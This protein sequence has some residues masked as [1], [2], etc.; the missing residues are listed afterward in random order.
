MNVAVVALQAPKASAHMEFHINIYRGFDRCGFMD[1]GDLRAFWNGS[2]LWSVGVYIGGET[3]QGVGCFI[4]DAAWVAD[5]LS[6]GWGVAFLWDGLQAPCSGNYYKMSSDV[7]S[8]YY[9]GINA[10]QS[11]YN[12]V[13]ALG[14]DESPSIEYLDLEGNFNPGT[15]GAQANSFVKGYIDQVQTRGDRAGL[16]GSADTTILN[17][18]NANCLGNCPDYVWIAAYDGN[19]SVWNT[20]NVPNW[21]WTQHQRLHQYAGGVNDCYGGHCLL[22]DR[23]CNG[24]AVAGG[25]ANHNPNFDDAQTAH[26]TCP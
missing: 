16:Y 5:A 3:A 20:G 23:D 2:P 7:S 12:T 26:P 13:T 1:D 8:A 10:G 21:A 14:A 22:I 15:C 6:I 9:Q 25:L 24:G 19:V 11:A 17:Y 18:L 4:P